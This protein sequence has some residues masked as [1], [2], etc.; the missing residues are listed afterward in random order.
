LGHQI[1]HRTTGV[2]RRRRIERELDMFGHGNDPVIEPPSVN[3]GRLRRQT[4]ETD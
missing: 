3:L 4:R 2:T 1:N